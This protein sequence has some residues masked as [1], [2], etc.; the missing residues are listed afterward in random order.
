[1]NAFIE[2]IK[3]I[4]KFIDDG[5]KWGPQ[6]ARGYFQAAYVQSIRFKDKSWHEEKEWRYVTFATNKNPNVFSRSSGQ[7]LR[8]SYNLIFPSI[9]Q[10]LASVMIG[11]KSEFQTQTIALEGIRTAEGFSFEIF[12]SEIPMR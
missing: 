2:L 8:K 1:M 4:G 5:Q 3:N 10:A 6:V 11:P 9:E 7:A 12:Q